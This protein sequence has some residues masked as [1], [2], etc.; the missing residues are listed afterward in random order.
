MKNIFLLNIKN[1]P[2]PHGT[3]DGIIIALTGAGRKRNRISVTPAAHFPR[4]QKVAD[5]IYCLMTSIRSGSSGTSPSPSPTTT[6]SAVSSGHFIPLLQ[7]HEHGEI[8]IQI[9]EWIITQHASIIRFDQFSLYR[10]D[11][12]I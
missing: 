2:P 5:A 6:C 1:V 7:S 3:Q 10:C 12:R 11:S 8:A 9:L 4:R